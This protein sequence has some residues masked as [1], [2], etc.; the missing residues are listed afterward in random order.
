MREPARAG[1]FRIG[2]STGDRLLSTFRSRSTSFCTVTTPATRPA[3]ASARA[4]SPE[5]GT[6]PVKVTTPEDTRTWILRRASISPKMLRMRKEMSA[7]E[8][9]SVRVAIAA[10][11][12]GAV[13]VAASVCV[14]TPG[15]VC[16]A[17]GVAV[18]SISMLA[19]DPRHPVNHLLAWSRMVAPHRS[20]MGEMPRA[21]SLDPR[22][23]QPFP[24]D[25]TSKFRHPAARSRQAA[26]RTLRG[27]FCLAVLRRVAGNRL[28]PDTICLQ[29]G[30][31]DRHRATQGI[32]RK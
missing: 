10:G 19:Q 12:D 9:T 24:H 15:R 7:S 26:F 16:A 8:V 31:I 3:I 14:G 4:T 22:A 2:P 20:L 13:G 6:V 23:Y 32:E 28:G 21:K 25:P 11:A 18:I 27:G 17:S 1:R 30:R 5:L 29:P